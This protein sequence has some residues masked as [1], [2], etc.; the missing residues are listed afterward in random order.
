MVTNKSL[1]YDNAEI[2]FMLENEI[3]I[4]K[5]LDT[6]TRRNLEIKAKKQ[7]KRKKIL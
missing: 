3:K 4:L 6:K 5:K 1:F 2:D 7:E